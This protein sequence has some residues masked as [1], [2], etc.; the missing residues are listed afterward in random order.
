MWDIQNGFIVKASLNIED[1]V[2]LEARNQP[3]EIRKPIQK[4]DP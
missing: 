2:S 4:K 3:K 1:L